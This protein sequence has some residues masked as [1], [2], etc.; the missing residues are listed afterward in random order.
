MNPPSHPRQGKSKAGSL[1]LTLLWLPI[2]LLLLPAG[3]CCALSL[4]QLF[5][6]RIYEADVNTV[7]PELEGKLVKL[8]ITEI[9]PLAPVQ[10]PLF[11]I[12]GN[13]LVLSRDVFDS[14]LQAEGTQL[15]CADD[16]DVLLWEGMMDGIRSCRFSPARMRSGAFTLLHAGRFLSS[17]PDAPLLPLPPREQWPAVLRQKASVPEPGVIFWRKSEHPDDLFAHVRF[18]ALHPGVLSYPLYVVARQRGNT[19]DM[20][21]KHACQLLWEDFGETRRVGDA[22]AYYGLVLSFSLLAAMCCTPLGWALLALYLWLRRGLMASGRYSRRSALAALALQ[23]L[24]VCLCGWQGMYGAI[25]EPLAWA[26]P[27]ALLLGLCLRGARPRFGARC[28]ALL[29]LPVIILFLSAVLPYCACRWEERLI[30]AALA[31]LCAW[32]ATRLTRRPV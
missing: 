9:Q 3:C 21:D 27:L 5:R 18:R 26:L 16:V 28:T 15:I 14:A 2:L 29:Y 31:I 24:L 8:K 13:F 12:R 17:E 22:G 30:P 6:E 20:S 7:N 11:G 1:L 4:E 23:C 10:D 19:L 32:G 25:V